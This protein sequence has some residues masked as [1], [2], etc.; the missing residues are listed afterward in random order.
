MANCYGLVSAEEVVKCSK[1]DFDALKK[2]LCEDNDN[3][4]RENSGFDVEFYEGENGY[5]RNG[6][7]PKGNGK[8]GE[9]YM[10]AEEYGDPGCLSEVFL[11]KLGKLIKKAGKEYLEFGTAYYCDK[12]RVGSCGGGAFRVYADGKLVHAKML[13]EI[14]LIDVKK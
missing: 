4:Q 2:Q 10:F 13:F 5:V 7:L 3:E 9:M 11:K 1:K 8:T 6:A 14:N 12:L